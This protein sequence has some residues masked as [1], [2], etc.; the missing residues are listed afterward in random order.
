M[1]AM[2]LGV[3]LLLLLGGLALVL[4]IGGI[5]LFVR[6]N[7]EGGGAFGGSSPSAREI[8]DQRYARGEITEEEYQRMLRQVEK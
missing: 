4:L 1:M 8:L 7:D 5:I 3:I 6:Q 2:G